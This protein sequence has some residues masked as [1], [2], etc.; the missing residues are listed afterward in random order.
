MVFPS[1]VEVCYIH[2]QYTWIGLLQA[3]AVVKPKLTPPPPRA[4][5]V[6]QYHNPRNSLAE[7]PSGGG[8][9]IINATPRG[10]GWAPMEGWGTW[11]HV[12]NHKRMQETSTNIKLRGYNTQ[13]KFTYISLVWLNETVSNLIISGWE[14]F[15]MASSPYHTRLWHTPTHTQT[16]IPWVV[17]PWDPPTHPASRNLSQYTGRINTP[18][19]CHTP[20]SSSSRWW[21]HVTRP[22]TTVTPWWHRQGPP[23]R[24]NK[25][26]HRNGPEQQQLVLAQPPLKP[27]PYTYPLPPTPTLPLGN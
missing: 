12:C 7:Y 5:G 6:C 23:W 25:G 24:T 13:A 22:D 26:W 4:P 11:K 21:D 16:H 27:L 18:L 3:G 17:C 8:G 10:G 1:N 9:G 2:V 19:H 15:I 20:P 14:I